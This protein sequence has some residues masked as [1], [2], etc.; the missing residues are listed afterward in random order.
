ME[1]LG[2]KRALRGFIVDAI[3]G[4]HA[5]SVT[6]VADLFCGTATV[7][8]AMRAR[9]WRVTANDTL[10]VCST[11]A[12]AALLHDRSRAFAGLGVSY[13]ALLAELNALAGDPDFI[14]AQ[15]SPA[16]GRMYLTEAN[17]ARVDA[18]RSRIRTYEP[19]LTRGDRARLLADLVIAV[20]SVS[21]TAGTYG[22]YLKRWKPRALQPLRLIPASSAVG[23]SGHDVH[24][25]DAEIL[26]PR[27]G[28]S[29]VYADP[30][31]TKRQYAAYYHLLETIVLDDK[32]A[33]TGS[34][35]LRP[36]REKASD[37]CYRSRAPDALRRLLATL[38][39]RHFFLS[40]N[41]DG[42]IRDEVIRELLADHG[43]VTTR[44]VTYRRYRSSP[45]RHKGPR[46]RER[47]YHLALS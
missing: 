17:A 6:S 15:Y 20:S 16:G 7:S 9:G 11:F 45:Q 25:L 37:W 10:S 14:H 38:R 44:E 2:S 29:V 21:N 33:V 47:L 28:A 19:M 42:Q 5:E 30:P 13:D 1:F 35:G 40:Y 26:A 46:V 8:A 18:I 27:L 22:C 24:C 23:T 39:C 36:W 34:T 12:E 3:H 32:P 43:E 41:E 31:Y 4:C